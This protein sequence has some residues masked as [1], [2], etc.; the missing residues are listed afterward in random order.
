MYQRDRSPPKGKDTYIGGGRR[1]LK[2][3]MV[4]EP[5]LP[6]STRPAGAPSSRERSD[7][8]QDYGAGAG[9]RG[10]HGYSASI[11]S[12]LGLHPPSSSNII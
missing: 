12:K 3:R 11:V 10:G 9:G 2:D 5:V 6:A 4:P 7:S 1:F 8:M